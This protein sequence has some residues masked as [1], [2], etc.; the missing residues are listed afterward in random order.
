MSYVPNTVYQPYDYNTI[1]SDKSIKDHTIQ[2]KMIVTNLVIPPLKTVTDD[3]LKDMMIHALAKEIAKQNCVE[4]TKMMRHDG[5]MEI[6][7]R[8]YVTSSDNVFILRTYGGA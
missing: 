1:I 7:A 2:G 4:F 6:K 5:D 8:I 3:E